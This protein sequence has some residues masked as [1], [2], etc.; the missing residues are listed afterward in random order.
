MARLNGI[1]PMTGTIGPVT[2]YKM[3]ERYYIRS[4]SNFTAKRV[5]TDPAFHKTRAYSNLMA[6][7][8]PIASSVYRG[9]PV[10]F[11]QKQLYRRL[12][13]EAMSLLKFLWTEQEIVAYLQ[14]IYS[15]GIPAK[16]VRKTMLRPDYRRKTPKRT[17][18]KR[19]SA[20][21]PEPPARH[22]FSLDESYRTGWIRQSRKLNKSIKAYRWE[23]FITWIGR[24]PARSAEPF[25]TNAEQAM[26]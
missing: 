22:R 9:I 8:S 20:V 16:Q 21:M 14:A 3:F 19:Q 13:G 11:K 2:I 5:K 24:P 15:H 4:R 26:H 10:R 18:R 23:A 7:A 1:P 25:D 6:T 17:L 12:V